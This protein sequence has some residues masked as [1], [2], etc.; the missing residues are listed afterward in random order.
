MQSIKNTNEGKAF[1]ALLAMF[2]K[3]RGF[4]ILLK[5]ILRGKVTF[6]MI[7]NNLL[8]PATFSDLMGYN[9]VQVPK[10]LT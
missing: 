1:V 5:L 9:V 8:F 2:M 7:E 4:N 10:F 3:V 6:Y